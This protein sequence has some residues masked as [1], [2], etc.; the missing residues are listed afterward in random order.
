M[1]K[2]NE[3]GLFDEVEYE[4]EL[5][6]FEHEGTEIRN[7]MLSECGRFTV[8]PCEAYGFELHHSGG[9]C[10]ALVKELSN[11][12]SLWLTDESGSDVPD[13][14]DPSTNIIGRFNKDG[15]QV[16][17]ITMGDLPSDEVDN[18]IKPKSKHDSEPGI[19]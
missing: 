9:G 5:L 7:P 4:P 17:F 2:L 13:E 14:D 16:A 19:G 11:G 6:A 12:D 15:E 8:D 3:D 18:T 1:H 10:M